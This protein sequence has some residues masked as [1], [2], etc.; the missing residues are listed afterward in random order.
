MSHLSSV[1]PQGESPDLQNCVTFS[2][3][4]KQNSSHCRPNLAETLVEGVIFC[5]PVVDGPGKERNRM[6]KLQNFVG[7]AFREAED[8]PRAPLINPS[9][10]EIFAEAPVSGAADIDH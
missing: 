5:D 6:R 1:A 7:G 8:G 4:F 9:T 3:P 2:P 10:G